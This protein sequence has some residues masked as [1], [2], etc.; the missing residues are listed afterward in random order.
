M[1]FEPERC[2]PHAHDPAGL[3]KILYRHLAEAEL[4]N[5]LCNARRIFRVD[6]DPDVQIHRRARVAVV[7][8]RVSSDQ[9]VFNAIRVQ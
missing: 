6:R 4:T 2:H 3:K 9:Q 5:S 7:I 1:S 8:Y